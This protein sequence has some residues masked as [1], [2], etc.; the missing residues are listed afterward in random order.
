MSWFF[1]LI[2]EEYLV[3]EQA[4]ID[5]SKERNITSR[6]LPNRKET[7]ENLL[8]HAVLGLDDL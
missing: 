6:T 1:E 8:S 3:K 5:S 2:F 4:K 7:A